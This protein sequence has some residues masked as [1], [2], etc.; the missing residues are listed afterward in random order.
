LLL[1]ESPTRQADRL[2][3]F[4]ADFLIKRAGSAAGI[5]EPMSS[6]TLRRSFVA[7]E[8]AAG[9]TLRDI[10]DRVGHRDVRTTMRHLPQL[11]RPGGDNPGQKP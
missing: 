8:H 5:D 7:Q 2:T 10:R 11:A 3:R 6:N 4:G 1:G 9:T